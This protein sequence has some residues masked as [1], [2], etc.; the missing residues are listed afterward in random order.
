MSLTRLRRR[1]EFAHD[2]VRQ[3]AMDRHACIISAWVN[4]SVGRTT[5]DGIRSVRYRRRL[6]APVI[7]F[8]PHLTVSPSSSLTLMLTYGHSSPVLTTNEASPFLTV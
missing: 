3:D 5:A 7:R 2:E 8:T 6:K 4:G 1:F